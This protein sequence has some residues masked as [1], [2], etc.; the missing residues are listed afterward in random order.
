AR[1]NNQPSGQT[2]HKG[3]FYRTPFT[4]S[5][6]GGSWVRTLATSNHEGFVKFIRDYT[7]DIDPNTFAIG[8]GDQRGYGFNFLE[9]EATDAAIPSRPTI[10]YSGATSYPVNGLRFSTSDFSDPQGA[11]T[12]GA[13][14]WRLAE[15]Y[16]PS[17]SNYVGGEPRKYEIETLWDTGELATFANEISI[18]LAVARPGSTYRARVKVKDNTGRWSHW[19]QPL[20]FVA[21]E[22]DLSSYSNA[23]MISEIMYAPNSPSPTEAAAGYVNSDFEFIELK[24]ITDAPLDLTG[25]RFTKGVDFDFSTG[26]ILPA[27]SYGLIARNTNA[28]A[29]RYGT[30]LPVFGAFAPDQLANEGEQVKLSYGAGIGIHD[31]IYGV[32]APWPT[33]LA[34]RSIV[35]IN[36]ESK[37]NHTNG[38]N[39]M[40]SSAIG[41]NP[42]AG[43]TSAQSFA[44]WKQAY[45]ITSDTDD[46]DGD[47]LNAFLEYATGSDPRV[48]SRDRFPAPHYDRV[49]D[50][51]VITVYRVISSE[52]TF[53][54]ESSDDLESWQTAVGISPVVVVDGE[55]SINYHF[56]PIEANEDKYFRVLYRTN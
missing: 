33:N 32:T 43:Q 22:P 18:P 35:L 41:G 31:F 36:P 20:Q 56:V 8:D 19:S 23:V 38:A 34:G 52:S 12:F 44:V 39:W 16:N 54:L 48:A 51:L 29:A 10:A 6:I 45:G 4:D 13:I 42:G 26:A 11:N 50:S 30:N 2:D 40:A 7:T 47:G 24:N 15:I 28:F 1:G 21:T 49:E 14:Q 37:P 17:L 3:N 9:S 55:V 46:S 5:R 25:L 27:R 53:S